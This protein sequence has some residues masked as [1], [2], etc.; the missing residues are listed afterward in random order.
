MKFVEK[1]KQQGGYSAE[2]VERFLGVAADHGFRILNADMSTFKDETTYKVW[3]HDENVLPFMVKVTD[4][5]S[6]EKALEKAE[7]YGT[8]KFVG[9]E[10][11]EI[12]DGKNRNRYYKAETMEVL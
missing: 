8:V 6:F 5:K 3:V 2:N 9:L 4:G 7:I 1:V 11:C 10:A 12:V